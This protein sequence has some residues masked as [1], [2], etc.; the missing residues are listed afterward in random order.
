VLAERR[1]LK[2]ADTAKRA[3]SIDTAVAA[4]RSEIE[5]GKLATSSNPAAR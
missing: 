5:S 1:S 4:I 2:V 3:M